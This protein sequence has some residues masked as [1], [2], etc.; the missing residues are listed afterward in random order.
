MKTVPQDIASAVHIKGQSVRI[1]LVDLAGSEE[2]NQG[3]VPSAFK[4][5]PIQKQMLSA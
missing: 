3:G 4:Y 1:Q 2:E 5:R